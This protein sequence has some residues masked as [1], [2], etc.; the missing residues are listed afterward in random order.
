MLLTKNV[1][2]KWRSETRKWYENLGYIFTKWNDEFEVKVEDLSEGSSVEIIYICDYC[3]EHNVFTLRKMKYSIYIKRKKNSVIVKDCCIKCRPL[4]VKESNFAQ[5][6]VDNI[7]QLESAKEKS[8]ITLNKKYGVDNYTKTDEF[9]IKTKE[10]SNVKYGF[11]HPSQSQEIKDKRKIT[12]NN[13][14]GVDNVFQNEEIKRKSKETCQEKYNVDYAMQ[15]SNI[16][17]MACQTNINKYGGK[18]PSSS[19][20]VREKMKQTSLKN[21][22]TEYP[23]Q[24]LIIKEKVAKTLY[25]NGT[26][27][28]SSQQLTIYN[29]LKENNYNVELN[30]PLSRINLDVAIFIDDIKIDLE[31]DCAHWHKDSQK[32]RRR[33]EFTKSQGWKIL[34]IKS[35]HKIPTLEQ[36]VEAINKL[37]DDKDRKFAQIILDDWKIEE[38]I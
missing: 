12:V 2:V 35:G 6:E 9:K 14:Y 26:I 15:N 31:Y 33:D 36:L 3:L 28:T 25:N 30:Y 29:M 20:E 13:K 7:F 11:D 22:G 21:W 16:K 17:E 24:N 8:K 23:I 18:S 37:V 34:R 19:I 32:D 27:K 38:V 1:K 10:T 5:Y 4:K